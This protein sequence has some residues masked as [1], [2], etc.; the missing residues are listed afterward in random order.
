MVKKYLEQLKKWRQSHEENYAQVLMQDPPKSTVLKAVP[1]PGTVVIMGRKRRGKSA[2]AH[3]IAEKMHNTRHVPVILHLP[4]APRDV[5]NSIKKLLP[6]WVTITTDRNQWPKNCVVIYDEAS[7]SAHARRTQSESAVD[8]DNLMGISGQRRQLILFISHHSRK[9]DINVVTDSERILWKQPT[10][11]HCLFERDEL[12]DFT[13]KAFDFFA[14]LKTDKKQ[15]RTALVMDFTT[16]T[17]QQFENGLPSYWTE[18]LSRLFENIKGIKQQ[19]DG[20]ITA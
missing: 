17:F 12:H 19:N 15:L 14:N 4:T 7:Q 9:L 16:F 13:M 18:D 5:R 3:F 20:V 2:L 1:F 6:D 10:Y 11:A 8:L